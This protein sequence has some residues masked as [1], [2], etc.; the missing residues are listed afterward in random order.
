MPFG[1][2]SWGADKFVETIRKTPEHLRL[3]RFGLKFE[4][5]TLDSSGAINNITV[6]SE[7][8]STQKIEQKGNR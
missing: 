2:G 8:I 5:T 7:Q 6:Q 1:T 3:Y 4:D